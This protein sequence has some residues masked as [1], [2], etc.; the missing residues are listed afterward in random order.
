MSVS[1]YVKLGSIKVSV[2][3]IGGKGVPTNTGGSIGPSGNRVWIS[4]SGRI[5]WS[6][7]NLW[8]FIRPII[9]CRIVSGSNGSGGPG[10]SG[11]KGGT[12]GSPFSVTFGFVSTSMLIFTL[13]LREPV[14]IELFVASF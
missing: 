3:K 11:P 1:V 13:G 4:P 8:I 10:N 9:A 14:I 5:P 12:S 2:S 6:T 7:S